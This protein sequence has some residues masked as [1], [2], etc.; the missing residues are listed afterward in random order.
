MPK[1]TAMSE[2]THAIDA[3]LRQCLT[4]LRHRPQCLLWARGKGDQAQMG[5]MVTAYK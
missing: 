4:V 3:D 5:R 1:M 2:S